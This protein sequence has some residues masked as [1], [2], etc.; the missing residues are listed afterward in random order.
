V[1][2]QNRQFADQQTALRRVGTAWIWFTEPAG[3]LFYCLCDRGQAKNWEALVEEMKSGKS[4]PQQS[5]Q[6]G[7]TL[8]RK[9]FDVNSNIF[10]WSEKYFPISSRNGG[11]AKVSDSPFRIAIECLFAEALNVVARDG[12]CQ[13]FCLVPPGAQLSSLARPGLFS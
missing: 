5:L 3:K 7:R 10:L 9:P 1:Q 2:R 8:L 6:S 13:F 11:G 4:S 12:K